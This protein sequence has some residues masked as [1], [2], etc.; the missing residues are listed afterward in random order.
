L[1][2]A[3]AYTAYTTIALGCDGLS[4]QDPDTVMLFSRHPIPPEALD[5]I[6]Q[7]SSDLS[8][9]WVQAENEVIARR[10]S[11]ARAELEATVRLNRAFGHDGKGPA[12]LIKQIL[13]DEIDIDPNKKISFAKEIAQFLSER[14]GSY[15]SIVVSRQEPE[16]IRTHLWSRPLKADT[17][18]WK[19]IEDIWTEAV[20]MNLLFVCFKRDVSSKTLNQNFGLNNS[21]QLSSI[22]DVYPDISKMMTFV[23]NFE[24][25]LQGANLK[26]PRGEGEFGGN[27]R[28][29][30]VYH[31]LRLIISEMLTN[32][33]K[34][35]VSDP[36]VDAVRQGTGSPI[37]LVLQCDGKKVEKASALPGDLAPILAD[38]TISISPAREV[39][40][41]FIV[42]TY[43]GLLSLRDLATSIGC[44]IPEREIAL[45]S[46]EGPTV[47]VPF[48]TRYAE[49][50][51]WSIS[52]VPLFG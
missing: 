26:T 2:S 40:K 39:H 12:D 32:A 19:S 38:L 51:V 24:V 37:R 11:R 17:I 46:A 48:F 34:H 36:I 14:L 3:P 41:D 1:D 52:G 27:F 23:K 13:S 6:A 7:Y 21:S 22:I 8:R 45:G 5:T 28:T 20:R 44:H 15:S 35:E 10:E 31:A 47:N 16:Q 50:I 4:D 18:Y 25:R 42:G 30:P 9:P 33:M 49:R 43:N 29:N